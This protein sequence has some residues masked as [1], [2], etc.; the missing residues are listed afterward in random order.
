MK[1]LEHRINLPDELSLLDAHGPLFM[2]ALN[3]HLIIEGG[4]E[5]GKET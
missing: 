3:T 5:L 2:R 4:E 1:L